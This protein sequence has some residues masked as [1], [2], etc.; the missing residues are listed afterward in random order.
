MSK[1]PGDSHIRDMLDPADPAL[2]HPVF[3]AVLAE[4]KQ[5]GGL[6]AFRRSDQ[7]VLIALDGKEYFCSNDIS[8][9]HCSTRTRGKDKPKT[10]YFHTMLSASIVAPGHNHVVPL[11]PEFIKPQDGAEKQDCET[12]AASAGW[13]HTAANTKAS[14]RSFSATTCTPA[15]RL[16]RRSWR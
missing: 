8:C 13:P 7:H 4:L 12:R 14:T 1:I 16:A 5:S 6:S 3:D 2:L 9:P 15:S 10:E 11:K